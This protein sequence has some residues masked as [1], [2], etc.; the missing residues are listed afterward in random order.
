MDRG[1][2]NRKEGMLWRE[3]AVDGVNILCIVC[4]YSPRNQVIRQSKYESI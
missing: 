3:E 4:V 2:R 1:L